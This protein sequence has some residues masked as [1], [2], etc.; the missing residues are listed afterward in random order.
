MFL[1]EI[2]RILLIVWDHG[3]THFLRSHIIEVTE[4]VLII[5]FFL[6]L[7]Q[8]INV[9]FLLFSIL[10]NFVWLR[11]GWLISFLLL[12]FFFLFFL[13]LLIWHH[14]GAH[15]FILHFVKLREVITIFLWLVFVKCLQINFNLIFLFNLFFWA[16]FLLIVKEVLFHQRL[17]LNNLLLWGLLIKLGKH[18][19]LL[20]GYH[21]VTNFFQC[22]IIKVTESTFVYIF[23]LLL[24]FILLLCLFITIS[25]LLLLLV[26]LFLIIIIIFF[27]LL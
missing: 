15:F 7:I 9:N 12:L 19:V 10:D 24:D 8:L 2:L 27:M 16:Y 13:V 23:M 22:H 21:R 26:L 1:F 25:G 5:I 3:I 14:W 20:I 4:V 11:F 17:L 18:V 6:L